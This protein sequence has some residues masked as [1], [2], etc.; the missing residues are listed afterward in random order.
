MPDILVRN[1]DKKIAE[2]LKKKAA[3]SRRS[4]S[5]TAR[6][7]IE[8]YVKPSKAE[9]WAE[10]DRLRESI[11]PVPGDSTAVIRKMRDRGWRGR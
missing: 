2:R 9:A 1:V 8:Q 5:E 11:G 7:A 3:A 4:V 10:I 6:A